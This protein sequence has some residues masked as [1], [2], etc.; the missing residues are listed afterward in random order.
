MAIVAA[1]L[2]ALYALPLTAAA[3]P[4]GCSMTGSE[5]TSCTGFTGTHLDLSG[6]SIASI[7]ADAFDGL[8]SVTFMYAAMV[9]RGCAPPSLLFA[10]RMPALR[11]D[12][13]HPCTPTAR[14]VP[15]PS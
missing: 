8:T 6:D 13:D 10:A 4:A 9:I 12:N 2:L 5:L 15:A 3:V 7:A 14:T 11:C 1:V